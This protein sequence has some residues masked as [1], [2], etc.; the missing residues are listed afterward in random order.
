MPSRWRLVLAA[1]DEQTFAGLP[2]LPVTGLSAADARALLDAVLPGPVDDRVRDRIVAETG[3]NPLALRELPRG[4]STAELTFGFGRPGTGPVAGRV[5]QGFR[6]RIEA[7]PDDTRTLLLTAAIEPIGDAALLGRAL[8]RLGIAPE[9]AAPAV[10]QGLIEAG[11]GVRF[12]HPLM[13]SASWRAADPDELRKVHTALAEVTDAARDPDRRAWHRGQA[14]AGPDEDIAAELEAAAA[15]AQSRGGRSA[16]AIFLERAAALTPD[17]APRARRAL[18][19]A[20]ERLWSGTPSQVPPLLAAAEVGPLD[21]PQRAEVA[22]L[23]AKLAFALH[24]LRDAS[25]SL[26]D[27]AD[28]LVEVDPPEAREVLLA[29]MGTAVHAGRLG[30]PDQLRRVAGAAR[31]APAGPEVTGTFLDAMTAWVLDGYA[32]AVPKL[33]GALH[34]LTADE[35]TDKVWLAA[36]VAM[37]TFDDD[38]WHRITEQAVRYARRTGYLSI[39]PAALSYRAGALLFAGRF[40]DAGA[41]QA[42]SE[43]AGEVSGLATYYATGIILAA[44]QGRKDSAVHRIA[45]AERDADAAGAGRLA[46]LTRYARAVLHNGLGDYAAALTA[47]REFVAHPTLATYSWGLSELAEAAARNR[48]LDLAVE[49]RDRL[50]ERTSAAGTPWAL[51]TQAL[52]NALAAPDT[53]AEEHYRE[54]IDQLGRSR[55]DLRLA[56]AR[57]LYGEWLRRA[58]RRGD[59]R[60]EL[61]SAHEALTSMGAEA[62]AERARRELVATGESVRKRSGDD[63]EELTGQEVQIARLAA[64]GRT[65]AE[66][67]AALFLSPRTVEWHLRKLFSKLDVTSRRELAERLGLR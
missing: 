19:A 20:G 39:L 66:I 56:R 10:D 49:A 17:P 6:D 64:A 40:A 30:P 34:A 27:A 53:T 1:G 5:E 60:V 4:L 41:L 37:E 32:V 55:Q 26:L 23:R 33:S 57:L 14:A 54:A 2:E 43:A 50:A 15:R 31:Q 45:A 48:D 9:A 18:A 11:T 61:R 59:A 35:D 28:A 16:A 29:A 44:Y 62:F 21:A 25:T 65:N 12:L 24:S 22:Q 7:L 47:A 8:A 67:A 3:G 36:M 63:R 58:N 46:D 13:R 52:A 42:E 51:G 38:S